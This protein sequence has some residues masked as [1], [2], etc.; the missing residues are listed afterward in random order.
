MKL[1][2]FPFVCSFFAFALI[3]GK[4]IAQVVHLRLPRHLPRQSCARRPK[5]PQYTLPPDKLAK[6]K[7]LYDLRGK[8]RIIDAIYG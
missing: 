8:L 5:P 6:S 3:P 4:M 2:G 7:A 1:L